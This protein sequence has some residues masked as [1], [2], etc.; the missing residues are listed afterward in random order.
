MKR[1]KS[2]TTITVSII[3]MAVADYFFIFPNN[4]CFGRVTGAGVVVSALT[5]LSPSTFS[6]IVNMLLLVIGLIFLGKSFAVKTTYA[7]VLLSSLLVL[8]EHVHPMTRPISDEPILEFV[9]AIA[10]LAVS[11][12]L[13]FYEGA[14][15]G[16][17]DVIAMLVQKYAR[18]EN[19][20][21]ALFLTDLMMVILACFVFDV[22]TALYS[23]V[24]L[25]TKSLLIDA[26]TQ[27]IM[28]RKSIMI[29][30]KEKDAIC[31][32]ILKD[33]NRGASIVKAQGAYSG[34]DCYLIFTTL[35]RKQ[36][37]AVR[38]FIRENSLD[39]FISVSSTSEVF[40]KGF[41]R[42]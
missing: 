36:A 17:T 26:V 34:E 25:T 30:C 27:N 29:T 37:A 12:A 3:I 13:L 5:S 24:G 20:G 10:L 21:M 16:G 31:S 42:V 23:F 22:N 7:T 33:L 4:F 19:I 28:L 35:T 39:A 14:S 15:S 2:L 40:G 11:S 32:F 8:F 1:L 18:V 9:F 41:T 38:T 6:F